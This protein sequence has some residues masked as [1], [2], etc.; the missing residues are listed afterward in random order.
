MWPSQRGVDKRDRCIDQWRK[1]ESRLRLAQTLSVD[2]TKFKSLKEDIFKTLA[3]LICKSKFTLSGSCLF[4]LLILFS[5]YCHDLYLTYG[6]NFKV[7]YYKDIKYKI[8]WKNNFLEILI[9]FIYICV[10]NI[11]AYI[12]CIS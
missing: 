6:L 5:W 1:V 4:P 2:L 3:V 10:Y 12:L 8:L 7:N 9:W 11:Y